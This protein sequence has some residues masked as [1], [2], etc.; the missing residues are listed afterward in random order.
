ML[1]EEVEAAVRSLPAGKS[2]GVDNVPSELLS[3]GGEEAVKALTVLCQKI[4][5]AKK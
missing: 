5:N 4:W 3:S 1:K 2:P